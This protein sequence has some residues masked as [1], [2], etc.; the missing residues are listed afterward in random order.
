MHG[1]IDVTPLLAWYYTSKF[2]FKVFYIKNNVVSDR[3]QKLLK[4]S[5]A[6]IAKIF[7]LDAKIDEI[8][9][10]NLKISHV[11]LESLLANAR[12]QVEFDAPAAMRA[13]LYG[14]RSCIR[15]FW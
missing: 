15:F 11:L 12:G 3:G 9:K 10:K 5:L 13:M 8:L 4:T 7:H 1:A 6:L 14:D 2:Y